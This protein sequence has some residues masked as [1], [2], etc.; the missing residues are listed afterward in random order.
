V[1]ALE[2][3]TGRIRV[4]LPGSTSAL[5]TAFLNL[6]AKAQGIG[7]QNHERGLLSLAFH[8]NFAAN[9]LFFVSY[10]ANSPQGASRVERY[11]VGA[12]DPNVAD[13]ASA[14]VVIEITQPEVAHNAGQIAFGPDG[15]LYLSIGDGG[16]ANDPPCNAQNPARLLGKILRLDVDVDPAPY[17]VP[18]DNPFVGAP[19]FRPEVWA[20][21][22]RNPWRFSFDRLT[23]DLYVG[24][25]GQ[26]DREEIDF[27]E[28]WTP[29]GHNFGWKLKEGVDCHQDGGCGAFQSPSCGDA[30]LTDPIWDYRQG[31]EGCAIIGGFVYRGCALPALQGLYF[32][33]DYC[34]GRVRSFRVV[35][36]AATDFADW[37]ADVGFPAGSG[38][39]ITSFGEDGF[40]ELLVTDFAA[41]TIS[42]LVPEAAQTPDPLCAS[43]HFLSLE[44]GGRQHLRV[45]P[46]AG[47]AGQ[48]Y[49]IFGSV[50]GT[51]PGLPVPPSFTLPL[52]FDSYMLF[53]LQFPNNGLPLVNTFNVLDGAGVATAEWF[54]PT[55][56]LSPSLAGATFHHAGAV[57]DITGTTLAVTNAELLTLMP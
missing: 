39:R 30:A 6:Q 32:N 37:T 5:P 4:F 16:G 50:S 45:Q 9:G 2:Q 1:F 54:A 51:T 31:S 13:P 34:S 27:V 41:G 3:H 44:Q 43:V 22:L 20:L 52:N 48:L 29:G 12:A 10:T 53:T 14:K 35:G 8:P 18:S 24:D 55:G 33:A 57:F 23:G 26:F 40:G 56:L 38:G 15:C 47:F 46:G 42:R 28:A 49:W 19:A 25:V 11:R 7:I 21:G 36:G 17:V